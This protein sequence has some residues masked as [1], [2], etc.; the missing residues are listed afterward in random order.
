MKKKALSYYP[1]FLSVVLVFRN[2]EKHLDKII[3]N[4]THLLTSLVK[5]YELI[6]VDNASNDGSINLLKTF[7]QPSGYPN[8]Q[9]YALAK[10]VDS[11]TG[12]WIGLENAIGDF[13]VVVDPLIDDINFLPEML[14]KAVEGVEVVF[15]NNQQKPHQAISYKI[16]SEAFNFIYKTFH[17][18]HLTKEAPNYRLLSRA[19]VNFILQ[20]P[21]PSITYRH[22]PVTG[23]FNRINIK[24]S[25]KP[26]KLNYKEFWGGIDRGLRLLVSSSLTP[27]RLA[28]VLS[29]FGAIFNLIYSC[30]VVLV[31]IF[32]TGVAD[33]W[34]SMSLQQ[35]SMF[36]LISLVLFILSEYIL[37][38]SIMIKGAPLYYVAQEFMS[39]RITRREKLNIEEISSSPSSKSR[40]D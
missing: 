18:I 8:L 39:A 19:V 7:T 23:G 1:I 31:G 12:S 13:I 24:Y 9:V 15:A 14:E 6:V 40:N 21:Q 36:F 37:H 20:Q 28:S 10:E 30:Y 35:S 5:D 34:L 29:L 25:A 38:I 17:G 27:M 16:V 3:Q 11:D 33:G 2:Q 22:L 32:N 26:M 4:T